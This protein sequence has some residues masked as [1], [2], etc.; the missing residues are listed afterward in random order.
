MG[1]MAKKRAHQPQTRRPAAAPAGRASTTARPTTPR[2]NAPRSASARSA[3]GGRRAPAAPPSPRRAAL[4]RFSTPI[5]LR[6]Q[7]LPGFV[8]PSLMGLAMLLGLVLPWSWAGLFLIAI[9]VFMAWLAAL[10]WPT[11]S[12]GSR[13]TRTIVNVAIAA[14]GVSRLLGTF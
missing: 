14:I 1:A 6:M 7:L 5:L 11:L 13:I 8:V 12:T 2:T 4:E 9:A 10:S 3:S